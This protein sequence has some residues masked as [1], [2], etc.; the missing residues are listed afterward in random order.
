MIPGTEFIHFTKGLNQISRATLDS[1]KNKIK[2]ILKVRSDA[3]LSRHANGI[4]RTPYM[5]AVRIGNEFAKLGITAW[6]G[7]AKKKAKTGKEI[8]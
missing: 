8:V 7:N 4:N 5:V 3:A 2:K 6:Q 1:F